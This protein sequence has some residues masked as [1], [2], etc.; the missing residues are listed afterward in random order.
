MLRLNNMT[1]VACTVSSNSS[2]TSN[3]RNRRNFNQCMF[4][5]SKQEQQQ[6]LQQQLVR[7]T[8][9]LTT[10]TGIGRE[11]KK[12]GKYNNNP[13]SF[14][15]APRCGCRGMSLRS[16]RRSNGE[17]SKSFPS[18]RTSLCTLQPGGTSCRLWWGGSR[19][20]RPQGPVGWWRSRDR[21]QPRGR[22]GKR[23]V[24]TRWRGKVLLDTYTIEKQLKK[25]ICCRTLTENVTQ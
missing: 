11:Q 19:G 3:S 21:S 13:L 25:L 23:G 22:E 16:L 10:E 7:R 12:P 18:R 2:S 15:L 17:S 4:S 14:T 24:V 9:T 5:S 20:T 6:V 1:N 8:K